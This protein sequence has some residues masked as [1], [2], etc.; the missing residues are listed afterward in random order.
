MGKKRKQMKLLTLAC[1]VSIP[2]EARASCRTNGRSLL[3]KFWLLHMKRRIRVEEDKGLLNRQFEKLEREDED[4]RR[5]DET[6]AIEQPI[7]K[8]FS[9]NFFFFFE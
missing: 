2:E 3:F 4:V 5:D 9:R 1:W 7:W 8:S 6:V